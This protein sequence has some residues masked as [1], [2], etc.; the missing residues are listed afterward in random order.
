MMALL[1]WLVQTFALAVIVALV[2]VHIREPY[3]D[4]AVDL[5]QT[6]ALAL[7]LVAVRMSWMKPEDNGSPRAFAERNK[8]AD[9]GN[10]SN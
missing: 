9:D 3:N 5:F 2:G 6:I 1:S 8:G 4:N 10:G 7:I